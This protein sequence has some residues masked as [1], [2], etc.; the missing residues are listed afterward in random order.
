MAKEDPILSLRSKIILGLLAPCFLVAGVGYYL[1]GTTS[2]MT[3][4]A[5]VMDRHTRGAFKVDGLTGSL[6]GGFTAQYLAFNSEGQ[7]INASGVQVDWQPRALLSQELHLLHVSVQ[8]I[9]LH[10]EQVVTATTAPTLP[11]S[12]RLPLD[13]TAAKIHVGEFRWFAVGSTQPDFVVSGVD[14]SLNSDHQQH[15]LQVLNA[16]LPFGEVAGDVTLASASPFAVSSQITLD[17]TTPRE[18]KLKVQ[19]DVQG[20]LRDLHIN[21]KADGAGVRAD[22]TILLSPFDEVPLHRIQMQFK[23]IDVSRFLEKAPQTRLSGRL[24]ARGLKG[25]RLEGDVQLHNDLAKTLDRSGIPIVDARAHMKV[26]AEHWQITGLD[27]KT[28]LAGQLSGDLVWDSKRQ[29]GDA[30][31]TLREVDMQALDSRLPSKLMNGNIALDGAGTTQHAVL[32]LTDGESKLTGDLTR[33]GQQVSLH[34]LRLV[35]GETSIEGRGQFALDKS[36]EFSFTSQVHKLNLAEFTATPPTDLN[37]EM[38][39][40]GELLP[41]PTAEMSFALTNSRFAGYEIGGAGWAAII[42][43]K[44]GKGELAF[45]LGDNRLSV[46]G[47]YGLGAD[48]LRFDLVASDLSQVEADLGGEL[49]GRAALTGSI[50]EPQF[51]FSFSGKQLKLPAGQTITSVDAA[52]DMSS[53]SMTLNLVIQDGKMGDALH[54]PEA[55][56][57]LQGALA[58]HSVKLRAKVEQGVQMREELQLQAHGGLSGFEDGWRATRWQ[59]SLDEF[60]GL[61]T[62]SLRL[63]GTTALSLGA[64]NAELGP[65]DISL[66]G[67][68]THLETTRWTPAYWQSI[69]SF[70]GLGIRAVNVDGMPLAMDSLGTLRFGGAWD[71]K[72]D[73]H[74]NAGLQ[75]QRE[76]G[77]WVVDAKTGAQFG[78]SDLRMSAQVANDQLQTQLVASGEKLGEMKVSANMPLTKVGESWVVAPE[79]PLTGH[80]YLDSNDLSWLGPTLDSNFQSGGRLKLDADLAGDMHTPRLRGMVQ[81]EGLSFGM[82]DQGVKL[83]NG[84][85]KAR[86]EQDLVHLD[87]FDFDSPYHAQPQDKLLGDFKLSR[88]SGKLSA[89]GMLDLKGDTGGVQID[90]QQFPLLQ[91]AD[92]WVIASG[93]GHAKF[94]GKMLI[95]DGTIRADAGLIDQPVSNRPQLDED[96]QIVGEKVDESAKQQNQVR[97]TLDLGDKFFIRASG[98]EARLKGNLDVRGEPGEALSVTGVIDAQDGVFEAYGQRLQVERGMVNFQGR[99]DDPGLNILA[100]RKGLDVEAGVEVSGTARKPIIRLVSNPNVPDAEKLSWIV[101]GRVPDSSGI[102]SSLLLSA[103]T[104]ILGG[105]SASKIGRA[106]GVDELSLNQKAGGG[107]PMQS[108]V[109]TV[110]KRLNPRAYLSYE[111]GLSS[112]TGITK[113]SYTLTPRITLVT[114]TGVEDAIDIFYSFRYR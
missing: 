60:I 50:G 48:E 5:G 46:K 1:L 51:D 47:S 74:W 36:Q 44:H 33:Q 43:G 15:H 100:Y 20:E 40:R 83:E 112:G 59:G 80:L 67:G 78:L 62:V 37:A 55:S 49:S 26:S 18:E 90:A 107:D 31:L 76:S 82:L 66:G 54:F 22:G 41:E 35:R 72:K 21:L 25:D 34:S 17:T 7:R 45:H 65:A 95:L 89:S 10:A 61:G 52:G 8:Q 42:N 84:Q 92:R 96:V 98:L 97:A 16:H 103:A 109:V 19:A 86:F 29:S 75:V 30:Q 85:L 53:Q 99:M 104:N 94:S 24:D 14:A 63:L 3:W 101:L 13:V 79:A 58:D 32:A 71:M 38:T 105:Q 87:L 56:F 4:V 39:I 77:D 9:D 57:E 73:A 27:A 64:E 2:G 93:T 102:D 6:F 110:G 68:R 69:G 108:Q 70:S 11:A 106:V 91:R 88:S 113:F 81:G 23:G 28:L 111:Q 114:R 12:L